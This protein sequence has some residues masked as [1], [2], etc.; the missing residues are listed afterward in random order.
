MPMLSDISLSVSDD[1]DAAN[2]L[3]RQNQHDIKLDVFSTI[4]QSLHRSVRD[5]KKVWELLLLDYLF[6]IIIIYLI[7]IIIIYLIIIIIIIIIII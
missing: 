4:F 7:I 3:Y 5:I 6:I 1:Q 2:R